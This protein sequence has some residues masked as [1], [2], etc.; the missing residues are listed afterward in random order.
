MG[1]GNLERGLKS[2]VLESFRGRFFVTIFRC[3]RF[4]R[5]K[6]C[7]RQGSTPSLAP[8]LSLTLSSLIDKTISAPRVFLFFYFLLTQEYRK[9]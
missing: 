9:A 2:H 6:E 1:I 3:D 7:V 5:R 8:N 4:I